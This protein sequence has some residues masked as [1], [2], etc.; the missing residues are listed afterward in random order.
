MYNENLSDL[1]DEALCSLLT[2]GRT[3]VEEILVLRYARLVRACARPYFLAGGDAE[4]LFQEGF[5][6]LLKAIRDY[7]SEKNAS[8]RTFAQLCIR[9]RLQSAVRAANRDKHIPLNHY[10]SAPFPSDMDTHIVDFLA[11]PDQ[12]LLDP[13]ALLIG[14]EDFAELTGSWMGLLSGFEA[15]ILG[16]YLQGLS[17][18]EIARITRKSPKS[19]NNAVQRVRRKLANHW[20]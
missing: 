13:E 18:R 8:F 20:R 17:Y 1:S 9:H 14:R 4:D 10:V 19:V 6:G 11:S 3:Q 7:D 5:L 15:E 16:H 2:E 12:Q